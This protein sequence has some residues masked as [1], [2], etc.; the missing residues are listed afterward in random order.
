MVALQRAHPR[1]AR[2]GV[3]HLA[4]AVSL[5]V[6]CVTCYDRSPRY[7]Q[8]DQFV[9]EKGLFGDTFFDLMNC[10]GPEIHPRQP[11]LKKMKSKFPNS[12]VIT[13]NRRPPPTVYQKLSKSELRRAWFKVNVV[14]TDTGITIACDLPGIE[15]ENIRV[16][17]KDSILTVSGVRRPPEILDASKI[18]CN[19]IPAGNFSRSFQIPDSINKTAIN[20]TQID[21]VLTIKMERIPEKQPVIIPIS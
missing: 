14:S 11:N 9:R 19:E 4:V 13:L 18:I 1:F 16:S 20:A 5:L 10:V 7:L 15:K 3:W 6:F 2:Y 8:L 12:S 21:G 17:V